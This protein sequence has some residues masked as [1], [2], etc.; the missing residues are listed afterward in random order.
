MIKKVWVQRQD[1]DWLNEQCFIVNRTFIRMGIPTEGIWDNELD[2][3]D[4]DHLFY[5][6]IKTTRKVFDLLGV[7]QPTIHNPHIHL[8]EFLGRRMYE[9][10][11]EAIRK[12]HIDVYPFFIKPLLDHK[13]FTGLVLKTNIDLLQIHSVPDDTPV[14]FSEFMK[15]ESEYRCFI[16]SKKL[17]GAKNYSGNFSKIL[18][19]YVVEEAISAYK[20]QPIACSLDFGITDDGRTKLIEIND[21]FALGM[22]GL[23]PVLYCNMILNRWLEITNKL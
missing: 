12:I 6:G 10:T 9:S 14:L 22:Y 1:N 23:N 19:F 18:N 15:F 11:M 20:E 21:G 17:V 2:K 16:H 5:G 4:K 3:I 7:K 8:P 13:L